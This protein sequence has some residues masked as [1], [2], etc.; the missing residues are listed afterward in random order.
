MIAPIRVGIVGFGDIARLRYVP[1]IVRSEDFVLSGVFSRT[2]G[3]AQPVVEQYGA[4]LHGDF[5]ALVRDTGIDALII[6]TPHPSHANYAVR[7]LAAGKHVLIEKPVATNVADARGLIAAKKASGAAAMALPLDWTAPVAE[8]ARLVAAGAIGIVTSMDSVFCHQGPVHAP[9]FF[10]KAQAEWGVLADLG[11]YT[12]S[13]MTRLF[14]PVASVSGHAVT[15]FPRRKVAGGAMVDVSVDDNV[16]AV[17]RWPNGLVGTMRCNWTTGIEKSHSLFETRIY[18]T[19][20]IIFLK[21]KSASEPLVVYSPRREIA[22]ATYVEHDGLSPCY[23][24]PLVAE[25]LDDLLLSEFAASIRGQAPE[26]AKAT[27]VEHQ[28]HVTAIIAAIYDASTT[29]ETQVLP[30]TSAS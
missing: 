7:A 21:P 9:W 16:G 22:G 19:E 14:G 28:Q 30:T 10:D 5:D 26:A 17:L 4:K 3:A 24:V 13:Q 12:I 2:P 20:G 18:G 6:T 15:T 25:N 23:R 8:T 11:V 29:G 1:V 27:S